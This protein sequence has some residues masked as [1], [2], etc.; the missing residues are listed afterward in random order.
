MEDMDGTNWDETVPYH[1]STSNRVD[2]NVMVQNGLLWYCSWFHLP[3]DCIVLNQA[4]PEQCTSVRL[5]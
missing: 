2:C 4:V 5:V 3:L 1:N